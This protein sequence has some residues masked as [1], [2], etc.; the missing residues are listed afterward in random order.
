MFF[1]SARSICKVMGMKALR[2]GRL[3]S[4]LSWGLRSKDVGFA[5]FL[6]EKWA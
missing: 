3:G 1:L 2:N 4:A 5:T 6:A